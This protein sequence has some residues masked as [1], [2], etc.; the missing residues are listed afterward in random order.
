MQGLTAK[1]GTN[2]LQGVEK[3]SADLNQETQNYPDYASAFYFVG[4][5]ED[6]YG[7]STRI[8]E[9]LRMSNSEHGFG[10]HMFSAIML[11]KALWRNDLAE[12]FGEEHTS[13][14]PNLDE[15]IRIS[16]E[17]FDEDLEEYLKTK[18]H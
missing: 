17:K 8:K 11:A 3:V 6:S 1:G 13:V 4:D 12:I 9:F 15:L 14:A 10:E 7:N 2:I 18:S 5:G 16:M